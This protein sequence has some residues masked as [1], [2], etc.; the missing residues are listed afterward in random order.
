[1]SYGYSQGQAG[2]SAYGYPYG[3]QPAAAAA[4]YGYASQPYAAQQRISYGY[5]QQ[6]AYGSQQSLAAAYQP[7]AYQ[8]SPYA[9]AAQPAYGYGYAQP[10]AYAAPAGY[11]QPAYGYAQRQP[12]PQAGAPQVST[13]GVNWTVDHHMYSGGGVPG[14][15]A[16]PAYSTAA[17]YGAYGAQYGAQYPPY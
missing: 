11:A 13:D 1:M 5:G 3:A 14:A 12:Y 9:A 6:A 16:P 2:M 8:Q 17:G 7:Q 10:Q 4:Q 15:A